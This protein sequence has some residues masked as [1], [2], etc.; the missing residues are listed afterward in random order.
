MI[1]DHYLRRFNM[2]PEF[3]FIYG[4]EWAD[5]Y[6]IEHS[7]SHGLDSGQPI[8]VDFYLSKSSRVYLLHVRYV[9]EVFGTKLNMKISISLVAS[10][11]DTT[12]L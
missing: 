1:F 2:E 9:F 7:L 10:M 6:D 3:Q 5:V 11:V 12:I 8:K 4:K